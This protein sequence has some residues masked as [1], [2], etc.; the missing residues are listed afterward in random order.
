ME[1][2]L[3]EKKEARERKVEQGKEK[4]RIDKEMQRMKG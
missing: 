1:R 3:K 4:R 2:K